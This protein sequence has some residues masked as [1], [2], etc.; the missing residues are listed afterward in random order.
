MQGLVWTLVLNQSK[1]G[2]GAQVP[3]ECK[4]KHFFKERVVLRLKGMITMILLYLMTMLTK[5]I[6]I[7]AV[8]FFVFR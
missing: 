5:L 1:K 8:T 6:C 3:R 2:G 7:L 4:K